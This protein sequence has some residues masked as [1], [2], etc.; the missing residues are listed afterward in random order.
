MVLSTARRRPE[1]GQPGDASCLLCRLSG[2]F[3]SLA[4]G[5]RGIAGCPRCYHARALSEC[6]AAIGEIEREV[7]LAPN[8]HA[9]KFTGRDPEESKTRW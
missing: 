4:Y 8:A 2:L 9:H 5:R 7:A 3:H 6:S 1:V